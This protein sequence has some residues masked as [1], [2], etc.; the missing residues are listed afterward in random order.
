MNNKPTF[1]F[2]GDIAAIHD[3]NSFIQFS[4]FCLAG[5]LNNPDIFCFATELV[6]T[7]GTAQETTVAEFLINSETCLDKPTLPIVRTTSGFNS[8]V[9]LFSKTEEF[10]TMFSPTPTC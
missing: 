1:A 3:L 2:L 10:E 8:F 5:T 7:L 4:F 9:F 6:I